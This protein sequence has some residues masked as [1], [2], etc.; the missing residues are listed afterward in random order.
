MWYGDFNNLNMVFNTYLV[1]G[2]NTMS[3]SDSCE[4]CASS[5]CLRA[6][7]TCGA[8]R[9]RVVGAYNSC[10]ILVLSRVDRAWHACGS[11]VLSHVICMRRVCHL[12]MSLALPRIVHTYL[13]CRWRESHDVCS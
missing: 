13:A 5:H 1:F 4:S 11:H 10:I 12:R 7:R 8:R 3:I 6:V 2:I 9:R